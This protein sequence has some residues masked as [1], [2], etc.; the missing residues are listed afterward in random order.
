MW[1]NCWMMRDLRMP[2]GGSK[3]SGVGREGVV[4]SID[5]YTEAKVVCIQLEGE[6]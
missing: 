4:E 3:D 2:F 1:V 5:F 6:A